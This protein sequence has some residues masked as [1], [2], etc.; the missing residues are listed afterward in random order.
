[1]DVH[2][3]D[4]RERPPDFKGVHRF[5][6]RGD[7]AVEAVAYYDTARMVTLIQ[8]AIERGDIAAGDG[9]RL[10]AGQPHARAAG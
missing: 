5:T 9:D 6:L 10:T 1:V 4:R 2:G 3:H 8:E 7:K